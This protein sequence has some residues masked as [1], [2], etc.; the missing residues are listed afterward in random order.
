[1]FGYA[2][3]LLGKASTVRSARRAAEP[4]AVAARAPRRSA[5]DALEREPVIWVSSIRP[6]G[7]PH[8]L[9][10]WFHWDTDSILIFS[11][12]HAQKVRNLRA[13]PR[14]M[15]AIGEPGI[16]FD[17]ELIEAEA[18]FLTIPTERVL[19]E[20]FLDKYAELM[21]RGGI[22]R[23]RFAE[24][25]SQPIR[26]RPSRFLD[27]GGRGWIDRPGHPARKPGFGALAPVATGWGPVAPRRGR[28][29]AP[30]S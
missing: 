26:L 16:D 11:K 13:N 22:D 14:V 9:P 17:V 24:V 3:R 28:R 18:E 8:V 21:E 2:M 7:S 29:R 4:P 19:P 30:E 6:D 12:P 10:L 15:V 5:R 23:K 1:M 27:W 20:A 25:Y